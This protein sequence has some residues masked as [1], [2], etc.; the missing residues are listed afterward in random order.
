MKS[1]RVLIRAKGRGL[2][3]ER[4]L[5]DCMQKEL[6]ADV[7]LNCDGGKIRANKGVLAAASPV[8]CHL[9]KDWPTTEDACVIMAGYKEEE[10]QALI[11]YIYT[12]QLSAT[13][14]QGSGWEKIIDDFKVGTPLD[15]D[16]LA[17]IH[18]VIDYEDASSYELEPNGMCTEQTS[19]IQNRPVPKGVGPKIVAVTS[20]RP[21][22]VQ[23]QSLT[24]SAG[25]GHDPNDIPCEMTIEEGTE[26]LETESL[27]SYQAKKKRPSKSSSV[28]RVRKK[29]LLEAHIEPSGT[30]VVIKK[31]A[32]TKR[33]KPTPTSPKLVISKF[34]RKKYCCPHCTRRFLTRGN[35]KN[36]MRI[37]S[38]D[39]PFQCPICQDLFAYQGVYQR[40]LLRHREN[41]E[42]DDDE[43]TPILAE[44]VRLAEEITN[45]ETS[46]VRII[47]EMDEDD[48]DEED[49]EMH[50]DDED[51]EAEAEDEEE[52]EAEDNDEEELKQEFEE[53]QPEEQVEGYEEQ[54]ITT[55]RKSKAKS[56]G[57]SQLQS[58]SS[59]MGVHF[60]CADDK[61]SLVSGTEEDSKEA[62]K[63][64]ML[65][66]KPTPV[67]G[68]SKNN[69]TNKETAG[70]PKHRMNYQII[71]CD[72]CP[73]KYHKWS[74]FY[75]HRCSHTGETPVLPCGICELE[76]P[77]IKALKIH[78]TTVHPSAMFQCD[79]CERSF[80][81]RSALLMHQPVHSTKLNFQCR[82]CQAKMRTLKERYV[83]E[84]IHTADETPYQCSHCEKQF[85]T[86][87]NLRSH[88]KL[89]A[90]GTDTANPT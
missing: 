69:K 64:P 79:Q 3:I 5:Y 78:K 37:H 32:S 66:K 17:S 49:M 1:T 47:E 24:Q 34:A 23:V 87:V 85:N 89:H 4:G 18:E 13:N 44:S 12:G 2:C 40:H 70:Q 77:N 36:H 27:L 82:Y 76:F 58:Q 74:A 39:K 26:V 61:S 21:L 57:S 59:G 22:I 45:Q 67:R 48:N 72:F 55:K 43:L 7:T 84:R 52:E 46:A 56:A 88:L 30:S 33:A 6:F 54:K 53:E 14:D 71:E 73:M 68:K 62:A 80:L 90:N 63:P 60:L 83:H 41:N 19:N 81:S 11:R 20:P 31:L 9:L 16:D 51:V 15:N 35:V 8:L 75:V 28:K 42:I 25:M 50:G 86:L 65:T 38:R 10:V 29:P